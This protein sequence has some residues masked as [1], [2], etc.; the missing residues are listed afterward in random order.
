MSAHSKGYSSESSGEPQVTNPI[1]EIAR[2]LNYARRFSGKKVLVKL[3]GAALQDLG[4]VTA[5]C[6]DLALM[7]A[8]GISVILVHGG[9][10][11]INEE[12]TLRGIEWKF[13]NG[14]R[15]TTPEMMDVIEMV[16][17]GKINRRI[18]RTL[19]QADVPAIGISGT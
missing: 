17:C 2:G 7:R 12:L 13:H 9:G 19:N 5:L 15:V 3:G 8:I 10:P 1:E 16:L 11:S 18:V 14:L 4:L 6:E